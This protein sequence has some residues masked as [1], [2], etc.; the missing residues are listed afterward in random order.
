M[1]QIKKI[2]Q[3]EPT[4]KTAY[5]NIKIFNKNIATANESMTESLAET[6]LEGLKEVSVGMDCYVGK[7]NVVSL[8][9]SDCKI[10]RKSFKKL[11]EQASIK[12]KAS[13]KK[14]VYFTETQVKG[15]YV[16]LS[17]F[18]QILGFILLRYYLVLPINLSRAFNGCHYGLFFFL[19]Y[20][21]YNMSFIFEFLV[22]KNKCIYIYKK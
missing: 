10:G 17:L 9:I 3:S 11:F 5:K 8:V 16:I 1:Y 13:C 21:N 7:L 4:F 6:L 20:F 18:M 22:L 15:L 2:A 12:K 14:M 19:W